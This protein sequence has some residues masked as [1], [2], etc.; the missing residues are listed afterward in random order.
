HAMNADDNT[1]VLFLSDNG[2]SAE[3]IIR[4]DG[5]DPNATLGSAGSYLCLGPGWSNAANTPFRRHKTWVHEGG[6]ATPLIVRCPAGIHTAGEIR[7]AVG[8]VV[9]IAP[10]ILKL[11]GSEWSTTYEITTLPPPPGRDLAPTFNADC[12]IDRDCLWW[13]HE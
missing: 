3:L 7:H 6:I 4:G 11:A 12:Q 2:A 13:L 8:H 10:T 1:L 5:H 9:D